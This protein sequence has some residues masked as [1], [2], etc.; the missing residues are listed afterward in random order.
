MTQIKIY[1]SLE[2]NKN[3]MYNNMVSK[4]RNK[5]TNFLLALFRKSKGQ[6]TT[7]KVDKIIELYRESK[8]S[9]VQTAENLIKLLLTAET[10]K[11][12][13]SASKKY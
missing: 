12:K 7:E 4:T 11:E 3:L 8:I 9:Q 2:K 13:K 10:E 5:N 6:S 1:T